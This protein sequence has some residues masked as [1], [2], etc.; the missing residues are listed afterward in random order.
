[1][2]I[3]SAKSLEVNP[4]NDNA[5]GWRSTVHDGGELIEEL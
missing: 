2:A 5:K 1:M 4:A 3:G